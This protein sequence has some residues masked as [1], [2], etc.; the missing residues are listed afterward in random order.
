[1]R[2][3]YKIFEI[4]SLLV[5]TFGYRKPCGK[6]PIAKEKEY[7]PHYLPLIRIALG[8]YR[9]LRRYIPIPVIIF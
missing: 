8:Y 2:L 9:P 3:N 6:K 4:M 5:K 1:M 7:I